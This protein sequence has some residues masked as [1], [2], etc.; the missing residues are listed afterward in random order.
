MPLTNRLREIVEIS[1]NIQV[2]KN[3]QPPQSNNPVNTP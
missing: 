1:K 3:N 2:E